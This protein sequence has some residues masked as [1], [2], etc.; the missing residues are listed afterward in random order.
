MK[1]K[2]INILGTYWKIIYIE[3]TSKDLE[4]KDNDGYCNFSNNEIVIDV[5]LKDY[6]SCNK[7]EIIRRTLRHEIIHAYIE[8][9][10]L[11]SS[12]LRY[13]GGWARNEEMVDWFAIQS[14]KIY[15]T[16]KDLDII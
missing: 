5:E 12:S 1:N 15:K 7:M 8:T 9:C 11:S 16:F 3:D 6:G 10:G 4:L 13:T 14:P 2:R